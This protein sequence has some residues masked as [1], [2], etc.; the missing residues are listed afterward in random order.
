MPEVLLP[1]AALSG[2][3]LVLNETQDIPVEYRYEVAS[4]AFGVSVPATI[5]LGIGR[6]TRHLSIEDQRIFRMARRKAG[7][8]V[9]S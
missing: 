1:V 8:K 9:N 2:G 7:K 3:S 6:D 4:P 5:N